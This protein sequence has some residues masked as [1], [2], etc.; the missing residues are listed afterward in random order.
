MHSVL[1][2]LFGAILVVLVYGL[3]FFPSATLTFSEEPEE[4]TI[5]TDQSG[6]NSEAEDATI[7]RESDAS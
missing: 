3:S 6:P 4:G 7:S 1:S 2:V 5:R